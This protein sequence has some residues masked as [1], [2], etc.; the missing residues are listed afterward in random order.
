MLIITPVNADTEATNPT[1]DG[2]APKWAAKIGSTGLFDMV[3]LKIAKIPALH[4]TMKGV[5]FILSCSESA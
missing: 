3:E 1:P 2:S 5:K 4:N